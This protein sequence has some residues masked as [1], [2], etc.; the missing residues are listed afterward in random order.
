MSLP[1]PSSELLERV[2]ALHKAGKIT[3]AEVLYTKLLAVYPEDS[4]I[5]CLLG[6]VYQ[7]QKKPEEAIQLLNKAIAINPNYS[8][9]YH[10]RGLAYYDLKKYESSL[11]DYDKAITINPNYYEAQTNRGRLLLKL[12][13][14]S[15][16]LACFDKAIALN[17][18]HPDAYWCKAGLKLLLGE[19]REGWELYEWRWKKNGQ[20]DPK[21]GDTPLW[22]GEDSL[23]GK[24]IVVRAEQGLGDTI[25][26]CRYAH[27]LEDLGAKVTLEVQK[28]LLK[29]LSSRKGAF[30]I[31]DGGISFSKYDFYC[32]LMSLPLACKTTVDTIPAT[33]PYL[34]T[35]EGNLKIWKKR[36]GVKSKPRIGIVWAGSMTHQNDSNRSI[37]LRMFAPLLQCDVEFHSI[38]KEMKAGDAEFL[39][40]N[41]ITTHEENLLDFSDTASLVSEMDLVI[42]VDTSVAHLAG[43]LGK[44]FWLLLHFEPDFRWMTERKDSPWYPTVRLFR[45]PRMDDWQSVISE[46]RAELEVYAQQAERKQNK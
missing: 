31:S 40:E 41:K 34:F 30:L 12:K 7:Q 21:R 45:Q 8:I 24:T 33:V 9:A 39:A 36:L 32:P 27:V 17:P 46:V 28:P 13:H 19:Y 35:N 14:Y 1:H 29:L 15:A 11:E 2:I 22:L 44:P 23:E 4:D 16:A 20:G 42:T 3:E 37:P 38:Q 6:T 26:F 10:N 25:Q 18:N 5:L 43:A